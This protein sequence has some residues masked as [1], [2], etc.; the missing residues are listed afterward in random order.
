MYLGY[1][2][3]SALANQSLNL[4]HQTIFFRGGGVVQIS[5]MERRFDQGICGNPFGG[6]CFKPGR[7]LASQLFIATFKSDQNM[8]S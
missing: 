4:G 7:G 5:L 3:K 1:L 8:R 2:D 6:M